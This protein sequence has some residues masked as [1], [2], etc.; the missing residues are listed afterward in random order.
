MMMLWYPK[1]TICFF[2]SSV[3]AVTPKV[4]PRSRSQVCF[5]EERELPVKVDILEVDLAYVLEQIG[6]HCMGCPSPGCV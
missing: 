4:Q 3:I 2:R 1:M 5:F 6:R